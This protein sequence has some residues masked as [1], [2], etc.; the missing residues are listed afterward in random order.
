VCENKNQNFYR[1]I[2]CSTISHFFILLSILWLK[3]AIEALTVISSLTPANQKIAYNMLNSSKYTYSG[4]LARIDIPTLEI[5][6]VF[7]F[8]TKW[9][10]LF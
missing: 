10:T 8:G 1:D 6:K 4:T 3:I 7:G 2:A 5:L 9:F